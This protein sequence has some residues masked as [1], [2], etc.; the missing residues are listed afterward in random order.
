MST[1]DLVSVG[2]NGN[3][4]APE[5]QHA[6]RSAYRESLEA[7]APL[8]G[9]ELGRR[10]DRSPRWGL[11]R[12]AEV[13]AD[14]EPHTIGVPVVS[15]AV[16]RVT[17]TAE[18]WRSWLLPLSVDGMM[19]AASMTLLLRRRAGQSGGTL[20]WSALLLG[21]GASL[22]ANVAAA[23]PTIVGRLVAAWPPVALLLSYELLL[24]QVRGAAV[25]NESSGAT[26]PPPA[27][28]RATT[29]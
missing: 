11:D 29:P 17:T 3:T 8:T 6:S 2:A 14:D 25:P 19:V 24:Q 5:R 23:D 13:Q 12:I 22:A 15:P 21:V 7:G 20:A 9:A 10:F 16:R 1:L 4:P 28:L 18:E 26:A 27:A